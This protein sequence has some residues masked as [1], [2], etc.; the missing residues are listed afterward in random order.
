M[1]KIEA[2]IR[3][4]KLDDIKNALVKEG[5]H[6]MTATEV[7]G[8]G[9]QKGHKETY[10]GAEYQV[11]FVPKVKVEIVTK[12]SDAQKVIDIIVGSARSGEIGDGKIFVTD[13]AQTIRVRTG[14]TGDSAI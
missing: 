10:R 5:F 13:L 8:Y 9:R 2:V 12:D 6:G 14:E 4:H 7:H 1:K 11:D 3:H